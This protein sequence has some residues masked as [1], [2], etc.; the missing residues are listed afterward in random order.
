[1]ASVTIDVPAELPSALGVLP[2]D[3]GREIQLMAALKLVECG[4]I[5]GGH[6]GG[7][8][9]R[10]APIFSSSAADTGS[11]SSSR[12]PTRSQTT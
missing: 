7:I 10:A 1:M 8:G 9:R 5:S 12:R 6:G 4:R 11:A 2:A 3:A